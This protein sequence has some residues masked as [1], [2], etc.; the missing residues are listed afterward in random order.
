[1]NTV[2]SPVQE[3][4]LTMLDTSSFND[5]EQYQL[6]YQTVSD[7]RRKKID[8][9]RLGKDK[10]LSL[11]VGILLEQGLQRIGIAE[12][13]L[14]YGEHGKPYLADNKNVFF[15]LSHS[16]TLAVCVLYKQEI[17]LDVQKIKPVSDELIKKV[18]TQ[19]EYDYLMSCGKEERKLLFFR[20]WT[21]KES[22]LK[23]L[24]TGFSLSPKHLEV[25]FGKT[26]TMKHDG[27]V[28]S[29]AFDEQILGSYVLTLCYDK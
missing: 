6:A 21:A 29:T 14:T 22:Y 19:T 9:Y 28:A 2:V 1:M 7:E 27:T 18:T 23:Y 3:P 20:L 15:S 24:G 10:R 25:T 12:Y 26:L 16:D 17:G 13:S 4:I 11:G 8:R 5:K